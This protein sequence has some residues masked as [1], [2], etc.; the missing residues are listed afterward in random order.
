MPI[1]KIYQV[2][3]TTFLGIVLWQF[4]PHSP[5]LHAI[6]PPPPEEHSQ[7]VSVRLLLGI[8]DWAAIG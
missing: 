2:M 5:L 8:P 3:D 6:P 1:R 7:I 4:D